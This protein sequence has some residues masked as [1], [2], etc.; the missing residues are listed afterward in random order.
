MSPGRSA[1]PGDELA[2]RYRA[3][4]DTADVGIL[5]LDRRGRVVDANAAFLRMGGWAAVAGRPAST[6]IG[7]VDGA[8]HRILWDEL[9]SGRR[10]RFEAGTSLRRPDG[11]SVAAHVVV[12][13][14]REAGGGTC[15]AIA[16]VLAAGPA[17]PAAPS[18][19][20]EAPTAAEMAV[21][22][23]LAA[24]LTL[25][26]VA[27]RLGLTRRGVDYRLA[28]LRHKLRTPGVAGA[29]GKAPATT[30]G[31][32]A[33]AYALGLLEPGTWPPVLQVGVL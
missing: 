28:R 32:V 14:V 27:G 12:T 23:G 10:H 29:G 17:R 30:A 21:L 4:L 31:V 2:Q 6:L 3:V 8:T 16:V 19:P 24:G 13:A 26:Q 15:G 9:V 33:R 11:G 22:H 1:G 5:E 25:T 20:A 18:R 7:R